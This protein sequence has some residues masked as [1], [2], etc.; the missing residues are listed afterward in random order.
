LKPNIIHSVTLAFC[1]AAPLF[2]GQVATAVAGESA[3]GSPLFAARAQG[4]WGFINADGDFVIP[5]IYDERPAPFS[6]GL[7]LVRIKGKYGFID[8]TGNLAIPAD[9]NDALPFSSGFAAARKGQYRGYIDTE[10][11]WH[12]LGMYQKIRPF[13]GDLAVVRNSHG[14]YELV[15]SE[16]NNQL[17]TSYQNIR[18]TGDWPVVVLH[19]GEWYFV[20][21]D[22]GRGIGGTFKQV[23]P[24]PEG[25]YIAMP[26]KGRW[27]FINAKRETL[28]ELEADWVQPVSESAA[29]VTVGKQFHFVDLKGNPIGDMKFRGI[30]K[31]GFNEGL[32]AVRDDNGK[33]GFINKAGEYAIEPKYN[34]A[35][36]FHHGL[37][38]VTLKGRLQYINLSGET[39]WQEPTDNS[40]QSP[41]PPQ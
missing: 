28:V 3:P 22:G 29:A 37:A 4:K 1:L 10:G 9:L 23:Y 20:G 21:R 35:E 32:A 7:A 13:Q 11:E 26:E 2:S 5:P 24:S 19:D 12:M 16:G 25:I 40:P 39:V 34:Q 41:E 30:V 17:P 8:V 6:D 31:P 27:Q 38:M 33:V 14:R 36:P 18:W 15:D